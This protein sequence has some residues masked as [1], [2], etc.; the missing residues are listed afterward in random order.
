M[1]KIYKINAISVLFYFMFVYAFPASA[2]WEGHF[3]QITC[4]PD[5]EY[6]S[7]KSFALGDTDELPLEKAVTTGI[8]SL[9]QLVKAPV[10]C[11]L[12]HHNI[13]VEKVRHHEPQAKGQCGGSESAS[14]AVRYDGNEIGRIASGGGCEGQNYRSE[15]VLAPMGQENCTVYFQR[16]EG[17][18]D[19]AT[20]AECVPIK[21]PYWYENE[22]WY[23]RQEANK[24]KNGSAD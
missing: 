5:F 21:I 8:Y 16:K 13:S 20:K 10:S 2:S 24:I 6:F 4:S 11:Q 17:V 22:G 3:L 23:K 18:A 14:F 12:K 19:H 15:I 1:A 9:N 7:I